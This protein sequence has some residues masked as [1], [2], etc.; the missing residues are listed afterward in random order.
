MKYIFSLFLD[1]GAFLVYEWLSDTDKADPDVVFGKLSSAFAVT[2]SQAYGLFV[3]RKLKPDESVDAYVADLQR[4]LGLSGHSATDDEDTVVIEQFISGLP[5]EFIQP[6]RMATA[7]K[8]LKVSECV[9]Q[10]RALQATHADCTRS[11]MVVASAAPGGN[12]GASR[13]VFC[14]QCHEPGHIQRNCPR[15][16]RHHDRHGGGERTCFFC[17][18]P[19][20]VKSTCPERKAWM[21]ASAGKSAAGVSKADKKAPVL[22]ISSASGPGTL[23]RMH[24]DVRRCGVKCNWERVTAVIDSGST[25]TLI[26]ASCTSVLPANCPVDRTSNVLVALDGQPLPVVGTVRLTLK[27]TDGPVHLSP[28]EVTATVVKSLDAVDASVLIGTDLIAAA[29]GLSLQYDDDNLLCGVRFGQ[30]VTAAVPGT[31]PMV[32][33]SPYVSVSS[34]GDDTVLHTDDGEARW[35]ADKQYWEVK[36]SW[37]DDVAPSEPVGHGIGEYSRSKLTPDQEGLFQ[38]EVQ[39]WL[40][41]DF[42]VPHDRELHGDPVAVLPLLAQVQEHKG[43]TPVRPCL[44]YRLLNR[45]L[46]S[47]PGRDAPVCEEALRRWRSDGRPEEYCLLDIRKAYLQVRVAPDLLKFQ[48]V[49]WNGRV[50]TMTRMGFGL[51]VAPKLLTMIVQWVT[52]D[53][54]GVDSYI[55]DIRTPIA[56]RDALATRLAEF[57]LPTK[58]AEPLITA[59][60]LGLQLAQDDDG[61]VNWSRRAGVDLQLPRPATKRSLFSWC[62]RLTGH[63]PICNWLRPACSFIKRLIGASTAW[64]DPVPDNVLRLCTEVETKLQQHGDPARGRWWTSPDGGSDCAVYVD[65]SDVGL[66]V[67]VSVDGQ[68]MEDRSWLRPKDDKRHINVVELEAAIKG[69]SLAVAWK[70]SSVRLVTDSKTSAAWLR[71]VVNNVRRVKTSGL[72]DVLVQRRLQIIAD[73]IVSAQLSVTI[74]WVASAANPADVLTRVPATWIQLSKKLTAT[75]DAPASVSAAVTTPV[76]TIVGPVLLTDITSAQST[77]QL[78]QTVIT[79]L[80][81]DLPVAREY[82]KVR[83]QLVVCEVAC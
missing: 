75:A 17:D 47:Q 6:L 80:E 82:S 32:H 70:F 77:D 14:H 69:L 61:I 52:R 15:R 34:D 16:K 42:L 25:H 21:A 79:Q 57:G 41:S 62:G 23:P 71:D 59:R 74:E 53:F 45:R 5:V 19:G 27:R 20:H 24:A 12:G 64:D 38:A 76:A 22:C 10:V 35:R 58:P 26:S 43:T 36:W 68:V 33:P 11:P 39:K 60:V 46:T 55:D 63:V 54:A 29:G 3:Q 37:K 4:L 83:P 51:N 18:K 73:L 81:Q 13:S 9:E 2:K 7:G 78:I 49:M 56:C 8:K 66:G 72:Y 67:V 50:Y 28:I 65:A 44:D 1:G 40:D 31:P 48:T 30:A